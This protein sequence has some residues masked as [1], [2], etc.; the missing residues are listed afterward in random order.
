MDLPLLAKQRTQFIDQVHQEFLVATGYGAHVHINTH[1]IVMLFN[2]YL[3]QHR[4][5]REFIRA[6][7]MSLTRP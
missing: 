3:D 4:P 7:I 5:E 1:G 2:Q 6:A